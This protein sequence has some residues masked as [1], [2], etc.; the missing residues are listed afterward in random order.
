[1]AGEGNPPS[2]ALSEFRR[3]VKGRIEDTPKNVSEKKAPFLIA[4]VAAGEITGPPVRRKWLSQSG[5]PE[6]D[7]REVDDLWYLASREFREQ[8]EWSEG[9]A[10]PYISWGKDISWLDTE[11]DEEG[12]TCLKIGEKLQPLVI[13]YL[14]EFRREPSEKPRVGSEL[15]RFL[16]VREYYGTYR[17]ELAEI[18]ADYHLAGAAGGAA[19]VSDDGEL[20]ASGVPLLVKPDWLPDDPVPF[21]VEENPLVWKEDGTAFYG[22]A[23]PFQDSGLWDDRSLWDWLENI[24]GNPLRNL[25]AHRLVDVQTDPLRLVCQKGTYRQYIDT[26]ETLAHEFTRATYRQS[27]GDPPT[28]IE[29]GDLNLSLRRQVD[30]FDL[31]N[32]CSVLGMNTLLVGLEEDGHHRFWGHLREEVAEAPETMNVVPAGTVQQ[33]TRFGHYP[34]M[35]FN[36]YQNFL[37]EFGEELLGE[38]EWAE[39]VSDSRRFH[40][41]APTKDFHRL[42]EQGDA[43]V[44]FLGVGL[45]AVTLKPEIL[46]V[47]LAPYED[48]HNLGKFKKRF[49]GSGRTSTGRGEWEPNEEGEP[50]P[51]GLNR[52]DRWMRLKREPNTDSP[53][54]PA[55]SG[56]LHQFRELFDLNELEGFADF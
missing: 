52:I 26:C 40:Q 38:D 10:A 23:T 12:N 19:E 51:V 50:F 29:A 11:P 20:L 17:R 33:S 44:F 47:C 16:T 56:C 46:T 8:T 37:R 15:R 31:D 41:V 34:P 6:K 22:S 28:E 2:Q 3:R 35:D 32:R 36:L 24:P 4:F 14:G 48:L 1:M 25:P 39:P 49:E 54:L 5:D 55:A 45:D 18:A 53:I 9:T 43:G 7:V 13:E 21:G 30:P 27:G 42:K